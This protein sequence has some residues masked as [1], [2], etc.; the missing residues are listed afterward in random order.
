MSITD[1]DANGYYVAFQTLGPIKSDLAVE[2][3]RDFENRPT[4]R[5]DFRWIVDSL[6]AE[7][8]SHAETRRALE[9]VKAE[10]KALRQ[11]H[12]DGRAIGGF[13]NDGDPTP[14]AVVGDFAEMIRDDWTEE[15]Q[16]HD[17]L[18]AESEMQDAEIA[19]LESERDA[20]LRDLEEESA[21]RER[22]AEILTRVALALKGPPPPLT[23]HDWSDLPA[24]AVESLQAAYADEQQRASTWRDAARALA[25][26]VGGEESG[27][28]A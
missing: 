22:L 10:V 27:G 19:R 11:A 26:I 25:R 4:Y 16:D 20:A 23:L 2:M 24:L 15:R 3:A 6:L 12:W 7:R 9:E 18:L 5:D 14:G 21:L 8:A 17:D 13:D 1:R 28:G